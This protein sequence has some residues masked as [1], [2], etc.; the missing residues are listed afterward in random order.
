MVHGLAEIRLA[1][2]LPEEISIVG[3]AMAPA[4]AVS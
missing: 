1:A 2:G 4:K 3:T